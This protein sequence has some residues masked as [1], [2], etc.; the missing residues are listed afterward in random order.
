IIPVLWTSSII[1]TRNPDLTVGAITIRPF[2]P[3]AQLAGL[4]QP[5]RLG[6][7]RRLEIAPTVRSGCASQKQM[8]ARRAEMIIPVLRTSSIIYARNP[9]LTVGAITFRPFGPAAKLAELKQSRQL[10]AKRRLEIA[11]TVRSG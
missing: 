10:G 1:Y 11:R 4:P 5:R 8:E 9:D 3:A 2:G 6:A 7:K